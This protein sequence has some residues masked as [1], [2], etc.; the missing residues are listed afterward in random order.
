MNGLSRIQRFNE[1]DRVALTRDQKQIIA[2]SGGQNR[3]IDL[4][5]GTEVVVC[6]TMRDLVL[7]RDSSFVFFVNQND[8]QKV[9]AS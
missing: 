6:D 2:V 1:G 9:E 3:P 4:D 8:V 5:A 7:V